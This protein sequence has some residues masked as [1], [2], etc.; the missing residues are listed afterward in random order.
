MQHIQ[1]QPMP[2]SHLNPN[3]P[4][5]L[6]E[7]I[8][9]CLEKA[10]ERRFPDGSAL[11]HALEMLGESTI[12]ENMP[13][14]GGSGT[15]PG[16]TSGPMILPNG[17]STYAGPQYP[18][19]SGPN[20][21]VGGPAPG[22]SSINHHSG[23]GNMPDQ[24]NYNNHRLEG[25]PMRPPYPNPVSVPLP[26]PARP[27]ADARFATIVTILILLATLLLLGFSVYLAV[28]L[29]FISLPFS[30]ASPTATVT[31]LVPVPNLI[32]KS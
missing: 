6:E 10:P 21:A 2:P 4:P 9:R 12:A 11:A 8:L 22:R 7:I 17:A 19:I 3:I 25:G 5:A 30:G 28:E 26:G 24:Q 16:Q 15:L 32:G 31:S 13:S 27:R 18:P 29:G 20:R 23:V 1:D 14:L